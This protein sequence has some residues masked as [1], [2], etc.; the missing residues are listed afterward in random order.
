MFQEVEHPQ[1]I[2]MYAK[3][4]RYPMVNRIDRPVD[5]SAGEEQ[6]LER[7]GVV[8]NIILDNQDTLWPNYT[9]PPTVSTRGLLPPVRGERKWK[10]CCLDCCCLRW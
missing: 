3:A 1:I 5:S 7:F 6:S 8:Q 9:W 10:L 4:F 2:P